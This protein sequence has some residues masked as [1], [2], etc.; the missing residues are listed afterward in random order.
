MPPQA[1]YNR[2]RARA[3]SCWRRRWRLTNARARAR[4]LCV[5]VCARARAQLLAEAV[6]INSSFKSDV[7]LD[8][9]GKARP[10]PITII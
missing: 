7:E 8:D 1:V 9:F 2:A 3:R 4:V 10:R 6:V 5:C